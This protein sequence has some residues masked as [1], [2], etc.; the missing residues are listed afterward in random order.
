M[1]LVDFDELKL[2]MFK[3][4]ESPAVASGAPLSAT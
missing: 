3:M 1:Y 2:T 4:G